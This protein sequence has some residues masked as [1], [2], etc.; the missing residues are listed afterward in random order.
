MQYMQLVDGIGG[1]LIPPP[2]GIVGPN[3]TCSVEVWAFNPSVVNEE[4]MVSWGKRGGPDGSNLSF[5]Y[6]SDG[7]WGA[8]G[9]WG[10]PDIGWNNSGGSPAARHWHHLVYTYDGTTTRVYADG[11]LSNMEVLGAGVLNT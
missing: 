5:N 9:H 7:R 2:D 1:A 10:N 8:I 11:A 6:G 3:A 4:T